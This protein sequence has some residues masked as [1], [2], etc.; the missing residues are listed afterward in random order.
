VSDATVAELHEVLRRPRF[1]KYVKEE[2]RLEFL[3]ALVREAEWVEVTEVITACRDGKDNKF[4]EL[5][6]AGRATHILS[7]DGD[8]LVLHPFRGIALVTPQAFLASLHES[9][10]EPG[11][12]VDQPRR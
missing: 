7:G 6:V 4:L 9:R 8:L 10:A 5:A 3:A 12:E 1:D 2:N 11:S